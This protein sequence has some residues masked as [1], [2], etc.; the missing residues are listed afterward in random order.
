MATPPSVSGPDA[1]ATPARVKVRVR[2]KRK[3][4]KKRAALRLAKK[5][6]YYLAVLAA[7]TGLCFVALKI[8]G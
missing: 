7:L 2:K 4:S 5:A 8:F 1:P 3:R 6:L